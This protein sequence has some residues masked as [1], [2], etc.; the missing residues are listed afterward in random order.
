MPA[1]TRAAVPFTLAGIALV[2]IGALSWT[3]GAWALRIGGTAALAV[4]LYV[5]L[6]GVGLF[7]LRA[8]HRRRAA[9]RALDQSVIAET[10]AAGCEADHSVSA[11]A[12][13][14]TACALRR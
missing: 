9:E 4:G 1:A 13:C 2:V 11:C 10:L 8:D 6:A 5:F 7:R 3:T 12:T 14:D